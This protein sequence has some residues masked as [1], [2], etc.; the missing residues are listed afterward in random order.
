MKNLGIGM[1]RKEDLGLISQAADFVIASFE[2]E[3]KAGRRAG[4]EQKPILGQRL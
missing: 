1:I 3:Q 4:V 2:K